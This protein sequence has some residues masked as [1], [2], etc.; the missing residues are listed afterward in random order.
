MIVS[1]NNNLLNILLPNDNKVL[2]E[3]LKN[4]DAQTLQKFQNGTATVGDILKNLFENLKTSDKSQVSI[5]NFLKDTNIFKME[6]NFSKSIEQ[7]LSQ[8][9]TNPSLDKFTNQIDTL[10]KNI[11]NLDENSLKQ[12]ID[13]SGIFLESKIAN[14]INLEIGNQGNLPKNIAELLTQIKTLIKDIPNLEAKNITNL[15]DKILQTNSNQTITPNNLQGELK[16]LVSNLQNLLSNISSKEV[17]NL[18]NLTQKLENLSSQAQ[19]V[20]SKIANT[21]TQVENNLLNNKE[22]INTKTLE[23]L[24]T[25]KQELVNIKG[26]DTKPLNQLID[27]LLNLQ[28]LFTKI[29]L[30]NLNQSGFQSN[31]AT[32]LDSLLTNLKTSIQN[33][34]SSSE[35]LN[36]HQNINKTIHKLETIIN[37]LIQNPNNFLPKESNPIQNDMKAL[38]LQVQAELIS[39]GDSNSQETIK[40]IDRLITQIEYHQ[41]QS[42]VSNSNNV[43]IPFLWDMLDEGSISMKKINEDKF[44][45]EINLSLKEFGETNL[46]LALYDKNKL[47]LTIYASKDSFKKT[48]Q[49]SLPKLRSSL[50][51]VDLIPVNIKIVNIKKEDTKEQKQMN[52]FNQNNDFINPSFDL[53]IRV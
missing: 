38:L 37:N 41:L 13:K 48:L 10:L 19:L 9:K 39:K 53:D 26:I 47:D 23:T 50:N 11:T 45:C 12:M 16:T 33:L 51:S 28:N 22:I 34:S 20:E 46:L 21:N 6:Q 4:A 5:Q 15:I 7:V 3:T 18:S 17:T 25:L 8:L 2:K 35:N 44:Y 29:D 24:L 30:P 52:Q 32:N 14:Q 42:L 36:L 1:N 27:K 49:E 31:F 40:Q 43:Y